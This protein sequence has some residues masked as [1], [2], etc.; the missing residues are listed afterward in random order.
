MTK[1][2]KRISRL[3]SHIDGWLSDSE[4]ELLYKLAK[5]VPAEQAIVEIGSWVGKS[6]VWLAKG[7]MAGQNCRVY[8]IAPHAQTR[9]DRGLGKVSTYPAFLSNIAKAKVDGIIVPFSGSS[10]AVSECWQKEVGLL[11][12]DVSHD[13]KDIEHH[14]LCWKPHLSMNALV[15]LHDCDHP[16]LAEFVDNH[17]RFSS[18]FTVVHS[19]DTVIVARRV[20]CAHYW[21]IDPQNTGTCRHCGTRR[22]PS[23]LFS[24]PCSGQG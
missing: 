16:G 12:L 24:T 19:I 4:G 2:I 11:W 23:S 15:A 21:D 10:I 7:A 17:F 22:D 5:A 13:Y 8:S 3:T 20:I 9:I 6:T 18:D 14:F 1:E